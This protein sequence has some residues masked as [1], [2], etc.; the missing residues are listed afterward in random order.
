MKLVVLSDIHIDLPGEGQKFPDNL[1][2]LEKAI[3]RVNAAYWDADLVVFAGDLVDRGVLQAPYDVFR[4][5]LERLDP[6]YALTVGNHDSRTVF[7]DVLGRAYCDDGGYVQSAHEFDGIHV[8]VL[9]SASDL[10]APQGFRGARDPRGQ[11]CARRLDQLERWL[12]ATNGQPVVVVLHHPPLQL[13]ISSDTMALQDPTAFVDLL[14]AHGDV[15]HVLS[16]HIHMTTTA[17][18]RGIPFTTIAGNCTTTAEDF[19]RRENKVRRA[20]PAQMAILLSDADQTTVHFDNYMDA[21]P[22]FST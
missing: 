14:V 13:G 19:G 12:R 8:L 17:F 5:A 15:R 18:H 4:A 3:N 10:P 2:R 20:G 16:G 9:D 21:H 1:A 11:L 7:C 22:D 6:P